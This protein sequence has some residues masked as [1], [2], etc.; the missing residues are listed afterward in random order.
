MTDK[1]KAQDAL[2]RLRNAAAM[3]IKVSAVY[4]KAQLSPF[5]IKSLVS[6]AQYFTGNSPKTSKPLTD[7]EA[8]AIN[9]VLDGI[10]AGL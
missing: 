9:A 6:G 5:R 1:N 8:D 2:E 3:G 7:A 4:S 10:K